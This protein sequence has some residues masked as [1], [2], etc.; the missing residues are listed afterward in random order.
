MPRPK[1]L[2]PPCRSD[3]RLS[4]SR[5]AAD[6][7]GAEKLQLERSLRAAALPFVALRLPDVLGANENTGRQQRLLLRL[8]KGDAIGTAIEEVSAK[9]AP[10]VPKGSGG[11][12]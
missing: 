3:L 9:H 2:G 10:P 6:A 1:C 7:Y 8:L 4:A 12:H 5:A 11:E